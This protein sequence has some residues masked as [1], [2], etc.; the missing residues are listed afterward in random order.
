MTQT[1]DLSRIRDLARAK[2]IKSA[3]DLARRL[4]LGGGEVGGTANRLWSGKSGDTRS[5]HKTRVKLRAVKP[6]KLAA[7]LGVEVAVLTGEAPMPKVQSNDS[8][9][10]DMVLRL[11]TLKAVVNT[12]AANALAL[13]AIRYRVSMTT[14]IEL[15]ALL[16]H[17]LA[18]RSLKHRRE[19]LTEIRETHDRLNAIG[20]ERAPHLPTPA[21]RMLSDEAL[22]AENNSIKAEDIFANSDEVYEAQEF[23]DDPEGHN[24]F[25]E[26][27]RR[28]AAG[29]PGI[30]DEIVI[31]PREVSYTISRD[32]A[33]E[34]CAGDKQLAD[35]VLDGRVHLTGLRGLL[36]ADKTAERVAELRRRLD[37]YWAE[38]EKRFGLRKHFE[39][40]PI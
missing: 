12:Q 10:D 1:V 3:K 4:G 2:G 29:L 13:N 24:P 32:R 21:L 36:G 23:V 6:E 18:Q 25:V 22:E 33:L 39:D 34:L 7:V 20:R 8:P 37:A 31:T 9:E 11:T 16:F 30:D 5:G 17:I 28:L 15:A 26:E 38:F 35:A 27:V 14:Q 40:L 19:A